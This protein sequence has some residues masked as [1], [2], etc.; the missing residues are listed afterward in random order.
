METEHIPVCP[1]NEM[2]VKSNL[3]KIIGV[4]RIKSLLIHCSKNMWPRFWW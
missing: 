3:I 2:D 1:E 4:H